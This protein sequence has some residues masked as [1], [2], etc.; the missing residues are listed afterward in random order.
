VLEEIK[1][2]RRLNFNKVEVRTDSLGVVKD[3]TNKKASQM[4]GRALIG[5]IGQM[6]DMIGKLLSNMFI[7]KLINWQM[8]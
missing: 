6:M 3:I 2:A 1:L 5:R 4:H 7:V 8:L